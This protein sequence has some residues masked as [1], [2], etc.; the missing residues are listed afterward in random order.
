MVRLFFKRISKITILNLMMFLFI[1]LVAITVLSIPKDI[2]FYYSSGRLHSSETVTS[3]LTKS[4]ENINVLFSGNVL[5]TYL[6][7]YGRIGSIGELLKDSLKKSSILFIGS[8]ILSM[9]IGIIK[10]ILDSRRESDSTLKLLST[11][12]PLSI[13]DILSIVLVQSL[14]AYLYFNGIKFLGLGPI[15]YAGS[16]NWTQCIYPMLA[17]SIVPAAYI[18][19]ITASAIESVYDKEY[20]LAARGKGCSEFRIIMVHTIKNALA[21][22]LAA[23]PNIIAIMFSSLIIV[24]IV[25]TY[26]GLGYQIYDF[27]FRVGQNPDGERIAFIIF[28]L[29]LIVIYYAL[30]TI[31]SILRDVILPDLNEE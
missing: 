13:P 5:N 14:G 21:N 6:G 22:V 28:L 2:E 17:L 10:G 30:I 19:R 20:I 11:L 1:L 18:A 3:I 7:G 16:D 25:F 12:F 23:I 4:K 27:N 29:S 24:E 8:I 9:T 26:K 31:A 15:M